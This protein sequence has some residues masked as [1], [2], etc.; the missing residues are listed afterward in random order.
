MFGVLKGA[1]DGGI[2]IPHSTRRFPGYT[3]RQK[4]ESFDATTHRNHIFGNHVQA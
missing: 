1:A 4:E 3:K 2:H